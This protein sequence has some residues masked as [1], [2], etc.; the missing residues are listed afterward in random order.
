MRVYVVI[1]YNAYTPTELQVCSTKE[2]AVEV[3]QH[4]LENNEGDTFEVIEDIM[5]QYHSQNLTKLHKALK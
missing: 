2:K 1:I 4:W 5:D 3:G